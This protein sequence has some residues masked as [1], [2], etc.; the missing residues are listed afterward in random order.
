MH[1]NADSFRPLGEDEQLKRKQ[2]TLKTEVHLNLHSHAKLLS[3]PSNI[4]L[5]VDLDLQMSTIAL[6]NQNEWTLAFIEY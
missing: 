4:S 5:M 6:C 2:K 1:S 3:Q